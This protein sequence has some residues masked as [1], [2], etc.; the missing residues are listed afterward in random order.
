MES[1][2]PPHYQEK[3]NNKGELPH[4]LFTKEHKDLMSAS[5]KWMKNTASH[6][7]V[8]ATLIATVVFAA[9]FTIPGGYSNDK[10]KKGIPISQNHTTFIIFVISDAIS[11]VF[12]TISILMF[13]YIHLVMPSKIFWNR[14]PKN[15]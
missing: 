13:L 5:E 1:I 12:A 14:Y 15:L 10:D 8:V 7:M 9:A 6:C 4:E 3:K 11:L 2:L